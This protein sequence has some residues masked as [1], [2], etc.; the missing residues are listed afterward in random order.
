MFS[1]YFI[2]LDLQDNISPPFIAKV[3]KDYTSNPE[4]DPP[5]IK[6]ASNAAEGLCKWVIAM[7]RYDKVARVVAPKKEKLKEAEQKLAVAMKVLIHSLSQDSRQLQ[8]LLFFVFYKLESK[9]QA[10]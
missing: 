1:H 2:F 4:F 7:D 5:K 9:C 3:R 8:S 10:C 6:T